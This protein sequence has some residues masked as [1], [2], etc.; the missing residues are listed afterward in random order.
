MRYL[1]VSTIYLYAVTASR[2]AIRKAKPVRAQKKKKD[3]K[4]LRNE[5]ETD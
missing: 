1:P 2:E 4:P 5:I 3:E